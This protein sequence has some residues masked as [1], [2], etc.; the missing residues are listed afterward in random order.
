[1]CMIRFRWVFYGTIA[2]TVV[3]KVV[4][5]FVRFSAPLCCSRSAHLPL[6]TRRRARL[7]RYERHDLV[8]LPYPVG[9][10]PELRRC[11]EVD[12]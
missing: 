7:G 3:K 2:T 1:L 11:H 8:K 12:S 9:L 4:G 6:S 5:V 10:V